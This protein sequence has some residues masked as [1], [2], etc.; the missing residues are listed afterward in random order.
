MNGVLICFS[1]VLPEQEHSLVNSFSLIAGSRVLC[2][3]SVK[4]DMALDEIPTAT[5]KPSID[6]VLGFGLDCGLK[7]GYYSGVE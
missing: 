1:L 2:I 4:R 7:P 6:Q 5:S 3:K